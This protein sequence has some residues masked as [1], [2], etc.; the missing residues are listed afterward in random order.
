MT[1]KWGSEG[2]DVAAK[3]LKIRKENET[4]EDDIIP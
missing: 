4:S 3:R 2:N 1:R